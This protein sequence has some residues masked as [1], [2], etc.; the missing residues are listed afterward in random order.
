ME[1]WDSVRKGRK[2]VTTLLSIAMA[3]VDSRKLVKISL[4]STVSN[5]K[6]M[7]YLNIFLSLS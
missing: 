2:N 6:E 4:S 7:R 3:N 5:A 1:L